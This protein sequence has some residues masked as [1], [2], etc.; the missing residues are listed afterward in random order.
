MSPWNQCLFCF[1]IKHLRTCPESVGL[2]GSE[3]F[4]QDFTV[5]IFKTNKQT[6]TPSLLGSL[7]FNSG[8]ASVCQ[9]EEWVSLSFQA[10]ALLS[11]SPSFGQVTGKPA[12][13]CGVRGLDG[14]CQWVCTWDTHACEYEMASHSMHEGSSLLA[15]AQSRTSLQGS[16]I[17]SATPHLSTYYISSDRPTPTFPL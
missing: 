13:C 16:A 8:F 11:S 7:L 1:K 15:V 3:K 12:C 6:K 4:L 9:D 17:N 5:E 2:T 14:P 10:L